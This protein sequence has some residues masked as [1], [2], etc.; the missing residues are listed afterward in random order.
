M[1]KVVMCPECN[2]ELPVGTKFCTN[3]GA[4]IGKRE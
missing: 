2:A 4:A 3:C 1:K